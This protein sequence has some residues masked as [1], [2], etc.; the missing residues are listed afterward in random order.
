[1]LLHMLSNDDQKIFM[2][3]ARLLSLSDN[4]LLFDGKPHE[5][6]TANSDLRKISFGESE[7][8]LAMLKGFARECGNPDILK[9]FD[10][11]IGAAETEIDTE[12]IDAAIGAAE[13]D[14]ER[15]ARLLF[16]QWARNGT[17]PVAKMLTEELGN[18][19]LT[20]VNDLAER[21]QA[22]IRVLRKI[23]GARQDSDK[24]EDEDKNEDN[25][26]IAKVMLFDLMLMMLAD[27]NVTDIERELLKEF[28]S[29][30]SVEDFVFDEL[31]ERAKAFNAEA[32]KTIAL[33]LE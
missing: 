1:M 18:I 2:Q 21:L 8:E 29:L 17:P 15:A 11:E 22:A 5:E 13:S 28:A 25:P 7:A 23:W 14:T 26:A 16:V 31:L 33:I 30:T 24:D 12:M 6:L 9:F 19:P 4:P 27:G 10:V 20:Q 3:I 32:S